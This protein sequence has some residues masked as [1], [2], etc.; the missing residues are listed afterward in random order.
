MKK[1]SLIVPVLGLLLG[2]GVVVADHHLEGVKCVVAPKAINPEKS[3]DH[4]GGK[5]YFCCGN[6]Q[7]KFNSDPSKLAP[8]AN[9]QLV[10]TKQAEQKACPFT[11]G[12]LAVT[13]EDDVKIGFCCNNCA[14][15]YKEASAEDR[16][17]L[18]FSDAA[19]DKG[20]KMKKD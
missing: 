12:P 4:R 8:Q 7:A 14:G 5:V 17:K 13:V 19:F 18:A 20:F 6:C 3:A 2:F 15:K 10:Q 9:R 11:G 1:L 16:L